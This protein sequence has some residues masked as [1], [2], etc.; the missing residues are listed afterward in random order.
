MS[1]WKKCV[2][3]PDIFVRRYVLWQNDRWTLFESVNEYGARFVRFCDHRGHEYRGI[4][5]MRLGFG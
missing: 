1:H 4:V 3:E 2:S 5:K